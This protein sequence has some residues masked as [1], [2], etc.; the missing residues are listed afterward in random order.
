M[1]PVDNDGGGGGNPLLPGLPTMPKLPGLPGLPDVPGAIGG[2]VLDEMAESFQ[3]ATGWLI[4]NTASWW[5][6][7]PSPDLQ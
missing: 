6:H 5:V 4:S 7:T 2:H 3:S 1:Q